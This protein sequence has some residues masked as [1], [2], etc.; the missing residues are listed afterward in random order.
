MFSNDEGIDVQEI[1]PTV[2]GTVGIQDMITLTMNKT[3][4]AQPIRY[5]SEVSIALEELALAGVENVQVIRAADDTRLFDASARMVRQRYIAY[6]NAYELLL[7]NPVDYI[8]ACNVVAGK[9]GDGLYNNN[10]A[11]DT[12]GASV[13]F[14]YDPELYT[15]M[16]AAGSAYALA[17]AKTSAWTVGDI[18]A[19]QQ[20]DLAGLPGFVAGAEADF[21]KVAVVADEDLV[22]QLA[23]ACYTL[24]NN[25]NYCIGTVR[26]I[27]P[28]EYGTIMELSL[29]TDATT[30]VGVDAVANRPFVTATG[31]TWATARYSS[32]AT[33][34]NDYT[35]LTVVGGAD[36]GT[37]NQQVLRDI[38]A[39]S[40]IADANAIFAVYSEATQPTPGAVYSNVEAISWKTLFGTPSTSTMRKWQKHI[41][42]F[43]NIDFNGQMSFIEMDGVTDANNDGIGD[44]YRMFATSTHEKPTGETDI[45]VIKDNNDFA[46]DLGVYID[47]VAANSVL[48]ST[49]N[50]TKISST[51][52]KNVTNVAGIGQIIGWYALVKTNRA[53]TRLPTSVF[54][55]LGSLGGRGVSELTRNRFQ[56]FFT[57]DNVYRLARD[58]T[59]GKFISNTIRTTFVNRFT[60]RIVKDAVDVASALGRSYLGAAETPEVRASIKQALEQEFLRWVAPEDGRLRAPAVVEVISDGSDS[61]IGKIIIKLR[62]KVPNEILEVAVQTTLE[63]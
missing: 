62:L 2:A 40:R 16:T 33:A 38:E 22:Y 41:N 37:T 7:D 4:G 27:N 56:V 3:T 25:G 10:T 28:V 24:S 21:E 45:I 5:P 39:C 14:I 12:T 52:V 6:E 11:G 31:T 58:I 36:A 43:G 55:Q 13:E 48:N 9:K 49:I 44:N 29:G 53:T 8:Y 63:R 30:H 61:V 51:S 59:M 54:S 18:L 57:E 46:V 1:F 50:T 42:A 35:D 15:T 19:L 26:T 32:T 23:D 60:T 17:N 34:L 20:I 47:C